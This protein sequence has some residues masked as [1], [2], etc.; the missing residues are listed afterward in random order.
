M[1]SMST[2]E[3]PLVVAAYDFSR[4]DTVVDVG[5]GHGMLLGAVLQKWSKT[6]GI[7]FDFESVV[8][9]APALLEAA[10]VLQRCEM[11]GGSFFEYVPSG[12]D[13]YVL[14]HIIHDW[15]D[16]DALHILRNVRAAMKPDATLVLIEMVV[17]DDEREHMSKMLDLEML[18]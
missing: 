7:L 18:V 1:T 2:M 15:P 10:G 3:T 4:F 16:D 6:R 5:G 11:I 8:E 14:K 17:P 9:G 12:G 13:A